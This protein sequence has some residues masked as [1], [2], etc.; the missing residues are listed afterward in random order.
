MKFAKLMNAISIFGCWLSFLL[1]EMLN[2]TSRL[3][4]IDAN[5]TIAYT[6]ISW[7]L[8]V[9]LLSHIAANYV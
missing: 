8:D 5:P 9:I 2:A 7:F 1:H 3:A 4:I 6:R